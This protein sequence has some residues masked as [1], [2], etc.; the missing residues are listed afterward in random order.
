MTSGRNRRL[1][2]LE[3]SEPP[4][5]RQRFVFLRK[6]EPA[7]EPEAGEQLTVCRWREDSDDRT[8]TNVRSAP[9][10]DDLTI[11]GGVVLPGLPIVGADPA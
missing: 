5:L 8:Q 3:A 1:A 11:R 7:P 10:G 9:A 4:P 2:R 6:G